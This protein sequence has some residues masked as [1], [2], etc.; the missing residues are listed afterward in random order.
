[1]AEDIKTTLQFQADITDFKAA[2]QEANQAI[3]LAN[4]EFKAAASGMDDWGSS[5][6]GLSAKLRQLSAVQ[7][8]EQRK[9]DTLKAAYAAVAEEQGAN[10]RA[11]V[12]LQTK[13]NNQQ[14]AVNKAQR[15]HDA[16]AAKL[17]DVEAAA[18][19]A[20]SDVKKAANAAKEA[21]D[22]A[23]EA[24]DAAEDAGDAA[25][26][27]AGGW[28]IARDVIADFVFN[29]VSSAIESLATLAEATREY[30][31]DMA[32][33]AQNATNAGQ[34]MSAMKDVLAGV[35]AVTGETDAA[36]EGLNMLMATGLDTTNLTKA[37]E[38]FAGAATKFD[39]LKFEGIAEG[40]Q[41]TLAVGS[42]VG[43]FA[44]LVERTGTNLEGFNAGLEACS[45][46]AERQQYVMDYLAKSGLQ[47]IHDG[48][49]QNNADLVEADKAQ[50]RLNDEMARMGAI[51]EPISTAFKNLGATLVSNAVPGVEALI[52]AFA[53]LFR[54]EE[55]AGKE[56]IDAVAD[57][58]SGIGK[59]IKD[60]LPTILKAGASI[61]ST[62][63]ESILSGL[64]SLL[65]SGQA[66][67]TE[68][69]NG[70]SANI[71]TLIDWAL[72]A[73]MQ[74][75]ETVY[76]NAPTLIDTGFDL[77]S[78]LV[79]GILDSLPSLISKAPVIISKFARTI[80]EN[81]PE[82]FAQ[83]VELIW[84]I[85][86]GLISAI[87]TL[88]A[89]IPKIITAFID[90]WKAFK[91][92]NLG[93][94]AVTAIKDGVTKMLGALKT[95]GKNVLDAFNSVMK[96]LPGQLTSLAKSA[97]AD[98][99][100][101]L[102]NGWSTVKAGASAILDGLVSFFQSL[103]DKMLD[104]GKNL[105]HGLW[106]GISTMSGWIFKQIREWGESVID[107]I[108][109]F[110]GIKS[111]S[112]VMRDEVGKMLGL[113]LAEGIDD[114]RA[115]VQAATRNMQSD[116]LGGWPSGSSPTNAPRA[117]GASINFTQNNYSPR[118][119][120]RRE[121]YRQTHNALLFVG[122]G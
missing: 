103:P 34:D 52:S 45:T 18:N 8:A 49:V 26:D 50:F 122:G 111:P 67:L 11:A 107:D 35:A 51:I 22:A 116:V 120:S 115:A 81:M 68:L 20:A 24:G 61:V 6:D 77:I 89:N 9:L 30:R 5:T 19:D 92:I 3:K 113:G 104:I 112:A 59:K 80:Y 74:F 100:G 85:V 83:G 119:L 108:K 91:W 16:Y 41:E 96:S 109:G 86:K 106:K 33:L 97:I 21:G 13:I 39:G 42:A 23:E 7:E 71:P 98:F 4:S 105:V 57:M 94:N 102:R 88:I 25:K 65:E 56:I 14:A 72:D 10:S 43:P 28:T 27:S 36:M 84:Q 12:E 48:Y 60:S 114:S 75:A 55:G 76:K 78:K 70:I 73:V 32:Q 117:G 90:V 31:R 63:V 93:K 37:A 82:I 44:E 62:L 1:M 87:P 64:P 66:L 118:A 53:K 40:L 46:A 79:Q 38:A 121:I 69:V 15:E 29:I 54:G 47:E 17:K 101:T 58:V 110:F 2:M 95:A 99:G